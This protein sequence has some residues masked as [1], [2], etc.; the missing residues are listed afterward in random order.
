[1]TSG[2]VQRIWRFVALPLLLIAIWQIAVSHYVPAS[3]LAPTPTGVI[4][5]FVE[6]L[7]SGELLAALEQSLLRIAFGFT[8]ALALAI[9]IAVLVATWKPFAYMVDPI[10]ETFRPIAPIAWV[11]MA[12]LW[13]GTGTYAAI[14]IV[15]YA[16]FFP[17][18]VNTLAGVRNIDRGLLNAAKTLGARPTFIARAVIIPAALPSIILGARLGMGLAWA[19]IIAAEMTVGSK[20]GGGGSGGI[21]QMM[22]VFLLYRLDLRYIVVGMIS[23]GLVALLIDAIFQLIGRRVS[24]WLN[25]GN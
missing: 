2:R 20:A 7:T 12:I 15:A 22:F 19:A 24:P 6:L 18:Y 3:S 23:I 11:P 16:A 17:I 4:R 21:G 9:V 8:F 5:G 1:M 10:L 14:F 13:F 25:R